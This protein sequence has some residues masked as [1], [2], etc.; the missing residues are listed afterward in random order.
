M[1]VARVHK[2]HLE[3]SE[4]SKKKQ[5]SSE[6][7][8]DIKPILYLE[9]LGIFDDPKEFYR[10]IVRTK[11]YIRHSLEYTN[12]VKFLKRSCGLN[13]CGVHPNITMED[14]FQ[15][16]AHHTP[17]VM[18]D[19]VHIIIAKRQKRNE[20]LTMS[21]IAREV[22]ELHYLDLFGIYPLCETC[23]EYAH[24]EDNDL[25]I[26]LDAIHGNTDEFF[27]IYDEFI[28]DAIKH[29]YDNIKTLSEGYDMI[30]SEIPEGLMRKY[31][32]VKTVGDQQVMS[33][34]M[35]TDLIHTIQS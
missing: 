4:D 27:V 29:K 10:F 20:S 32:Y 35:L 8:V 13:R 2:F 6:I 5:K 26:P 28:S 21:A 31:I 33:T 16:H 11:Y 17:L 18:E 24:G 9:D 7:E 1:R 34:K 14:G 12:Y 3:S 23:H 19:I 15:I 30:R 25:F 22:M